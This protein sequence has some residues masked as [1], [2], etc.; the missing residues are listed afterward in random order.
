MFCRYL[1]YKISVNTKAGKQKTRDKRGVRTWGSVQ[2]EM[3]QS[4]GFDKLFDFMSDPLAIIS[5]GKII[6]IVS[7]KK[8]ILVL[9]ISLCETTSSS[10][11]GLYFSTLSSHPISTS[12]PKS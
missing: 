9:V 3:R 4:S 10:E 12:I 5:S 8:D 11:T 6:G 1:Q 2:Q 7:K